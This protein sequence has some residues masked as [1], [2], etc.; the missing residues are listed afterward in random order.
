[1]VLR[2]LDAH[3][4]KKK[5]RKERKKAKNERKKKKLNPYFTLHVEINS[6]GIKD[7]NV[8]VKTIKLL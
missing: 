2:Q 1:M 7:L 6:K 8:R 4:Q 3:I 5:R